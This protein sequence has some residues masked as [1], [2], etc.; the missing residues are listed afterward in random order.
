MIKRL[1]LLFSL[2]AISVLAIAPAS[3]QTFG[4]CQ[5]PTAPSLPAAVQSQAEADSLLTSVNSYL[6]ES[7]N[8][9]QCLIAYG[10]ANQATL[11]DQEKTALRTAYDTQQADARNIAQNWNAIYSTFMLQSE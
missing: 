3:A 8:Y 5:K 2:I 9:I 11:T 6:G 7:Q 4:T 1:T 10:T